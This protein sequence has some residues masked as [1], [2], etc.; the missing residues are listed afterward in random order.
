V[1]RQRDDQN[2]IPL[3]HAGDM[4]KETIVTQTPAAQQ[5]PAAGSGVIRGTI[6][7]ESLRLGTILAGHGMRIL[8][9]ARNEVTGVAEYQPHVWTA[10]EFEAP[11]SAAGA[12]AT[13]LS[14][15][16]LAP[17]WY[18]N[19]SSDTEATIVYPGRIF[20]YPRGDESGRAAAQEHG[21]HCGVPEHQLDWTD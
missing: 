5:A 20:R 2:V 8:E 9:L 18:V 4:T 3:A 17:G 10:I 6:L 15:S 21:R 7:A 11:A 1:P 14:E 19:W 12:L 13:D 16:L